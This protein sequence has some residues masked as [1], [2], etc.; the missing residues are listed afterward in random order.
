MT[1]GN[2][3]NKYAKSFY[4]CLKRRCSAKSCLASRFAVTNR[5]ISREAV[6]WR[7][8]SRSVPSGRLCHEQDSCFVQVSVVQ[9]L[10]LLCLGKWALSIYPSFSHLY[11]SGSLGGLEPVFSKDDNTYLSLSSSNL[12]P[13]KHIKFLP[14]L[15]LVNIR[16]KEITKC[17]CTLW[18]E[19]LCYKY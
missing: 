8:F 9:G 11:L 16:I 10:L 1:L 13:Q 4:F 14:I 6:L 12:S 15:K 2:F 7:L 3:K 5:G 18:Y 17:E 19:K